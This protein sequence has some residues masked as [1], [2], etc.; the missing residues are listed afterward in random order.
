[1]G[2]GEDASRLPLLRIDLL[3]PVRVCRR[4]VE[5]PLPP[6]RKVRALLVYLALMPQGASRSRLC[7]ML[8][9][10]PGDPRAQLRW[11][12]SRLRRLLDDAG[13][14]RLR[15][16][17][18]RVWLDASDCEIDALS[19][20]RLT[21][22]ELAPGAAVQFAAVFRGEL[23]EGVD[24]DR[25]VLFSGWLG[26]A[27]RRYRELHTAL[28]ERAS[29]GAGEEALAHI[30]T[31]LQLSPFATRAHVHLLE[32][33]A[34]AGRV[35]DAERHL[36]LAERQFVDEGLDFAPIRRAWHA[37]RARGRGS[38]APA[39]ACDRMER[40]AGGVPAVDQ[41][42]QRRASI[43]VMPFREP[44]A[45]A[46]S[47]RFADAMVHDVITRLAKLR[48]LFVIAQGSVFA[49]ADR[50][51]AAQE[52]GRL[53][54]VDYLVSG[55]VGTLTAG[56]LVTV[57]LTE[58]RSGRVVWAER[59]ERPREDTFAVLEE[60]GNGVVAS[61][62]GEIE[63]IERNRAILRPPSSLDA[64]E[65]HHRGLWHMYR[66]TRPDNEAARHFF[67]RAVQ[68]DPT[69]ARA[70]A[71]LSFTHWQSA[72]QGWGER[73]AELDAAFECAGRGIMVD[74]RDPAVHWAQGRA[75]WLR[76]QHHESVVELSQAVELSPN[77]ALGHYALAFVQSQTG[78]P[79]AAIAAADRSRSLSPYDPL[80]FGMLG[81]RAMALVRQGLYE[82]AADAATQAAA[83]PNAHPHIYAIAACTAALAG[84]TGDAHRHVG[85]IALAAPGY[86]IEDFL[87]AF[88]FDVQGEARFR[89]GARRAGLG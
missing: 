40:E 70:Y 84:R 25:N 89:E 9:D 71:G 34:Q 35:R 56:M 63:R 45:P 36:D 88:R 16:E 50:Q 30:D 61:I 28:L 83:R 77:F 8:W 67:T 47:G 1:M 29:A 44:G 42:A 14:S 7:E 81:A 39:V 78:D 80:L 76:G 57:E 43:A 53:L 82:E 27:R 65:S 10:G 87:R 31:W 5:V 6:S 22:E 59:F 19:L 4:D 62:A 69:F 41:S 46:R 23:A 32:R 21:P 64:W 86:G 48:S 54:Q 3:G 33:L 2:I 55:V 18:D 75:L 52:A 12:L 26:A 72:F 68:L 58:T 66:F 60:L 85:A 20:E 74:D 73:A 37:M 13:R 24:V 38:V 79:A 15:A 17:G 11:A 51:T 49:L